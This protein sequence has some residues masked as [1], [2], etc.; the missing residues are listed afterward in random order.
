[1]GFRGLQIKAQKS[2]TEKSSLSQFLVL[3]KSSD[4]ST[5]IFFLLISP[6]TP[7]LKNLFKNL[8]ILES[9]TGAGFLKAIILIA[10]EIYSPMPGTV[11]NN[12]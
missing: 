2:I 4:F 1:M 3:K 10:H 9:T 12:L 8:A 6:L 11:D 7:K 5:I